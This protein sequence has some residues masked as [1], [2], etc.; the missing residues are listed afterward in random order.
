[1]TRTESKKCLLCVN[2]EYM[3]MKKQRIFSLKWNIAM[4]AIIFAAALVL[5]GITG[6]AAGAAKIEIKETSAEVSLGGVTNI[7]VNYQMPEGQVPQLAVIVA[8]EE[9]VAAAIADSGNGKATLAVSGLQLGTT[10]VAVYEVSDPNVADHVTIKSG[11]AAEGEVYT[12][13]EGSSFTTVYDDRIVS[14][15]SLMN[16]KNDDQLAVNHLE[17]ERNSGIDGLVVE[18]KLWEQNTSSAGLLTFYAN[19]YDASGNLIDRMPY[20]LKNT[21]AG[22]SAK[23]V[24]YIP[25]GCIRIVLE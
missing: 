17:I 14:Y 23:L 15:N 6:S 19:F 7:E 21:G 5:T 18:G 24:W 11:L 2:T 16:A 4:M 13:T 12:L 1:M 8:D 25:E 20:Y 9:M 22:S 10:V 3:E